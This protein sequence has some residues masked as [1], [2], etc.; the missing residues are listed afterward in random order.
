MDTAPCV[1]RAQSKALPQYMNSFSFWPH[2]RRF[3]LSKV[4]AQGREEGNPPSCTGART[5]TKG[6][7]LPPVLGYRPACGK[8]HV[9]P[10]SRGAPQMGTGTL[11]RQGRKNLGATLHSLHEL[12]Q[13]LASVK[14]LRKGY[15]VKGGVTPETAGALRP[16]VC[17]RLAVTIW[18]LVPGTM[19]P[20][21]RKSERKPC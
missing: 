10:G 7:R 2:V 3:M 18:L 9:P 14:C 16:S 8:V 15:I 6:C 1:C 4:P 13:V 19:P 5:I 12:G 20:Q 21:A 17:H 11:S